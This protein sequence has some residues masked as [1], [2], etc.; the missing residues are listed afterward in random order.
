MNI[1]RPTKIQK[2]RGQA[3]VEFALALPVLLTL[4][5]GLFEAGRLL[6]IYASTVTAA[7]QAVRY[8]SATGIGPNG[9]PYYQDC[10]GIIA[11]ANNVG[12]INRFETINIRYDAGLDSSNGNPLD[13][14]PADPACG[15]YT[16]ADVEN[17]HRIIVE[18]TALWQPIVPIV[19][20]KELAIEPQRE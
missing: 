12:F 1:S 15:D 14:T 7:R 2:T 4:L 10:E 17:G 9:M 20:L 11:A 6:F 16:E 18:V 13:L 3:M 5:Y 8:G 19:P